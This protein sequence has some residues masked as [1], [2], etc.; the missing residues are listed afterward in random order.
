MLSKSVRKMFDLVL[1]EPEIP[2]NTGNAMRLA[3]N[4]GVRLHLIK[5]LGF[6]IN[7]KQLARAG[8]DYREFADVTLHDDWPAC[9]AHFEKRR[10]FAVTT[11]GSQRYDKPAYHEND[12]FIFGPES[13]G[14]PQALIDALPA[15]Q[16]I[17]LPMRTA[18]RS[19][20]LSNAVAV[21]VYEAWRQLGFAGG[22]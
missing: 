8:M 5:P 10:L 17:R 9:L 12:V 1:Y 4:T 20:N 14:L 19:I 18:A 21:V 3:V 13:R 15:E 22:K 11:R 7:H 16:R 2:P 6:S